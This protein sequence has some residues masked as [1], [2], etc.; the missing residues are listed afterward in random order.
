MAKLRGFTLFELL[1]SLV[2]LSLALAIAIPP[3]GNSL[4]RHQVFADSK[5]LLH[6]V[7]MA[8]QSAV[9]ESARVV[10]CATDASQRC[11]RNWNQDVTVFTD[12]NRNN[13]IDGDDRIVVH[14]QQNKR[15]SDIRWRGFG[16]GYL[17]FRESGAAAENGAFTLCPA[18]GDIRNARQLVINRV[19]RAYISRDRDGDGIADYG[20]KRMPSCA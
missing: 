12:R 13:R 14:W 5:S 11:T 3:L 1:L 4:Q 16:P 17:R 18:D 20:D 19:G 10:V 2:L 9:F 8:R 15:R 7:K 6:L